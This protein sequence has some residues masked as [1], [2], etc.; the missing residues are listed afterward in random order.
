MENITTILVDDE[1]LALNRMADILKHFKQINVI[2][3][4]HDPEEAIGRIGKTKPEI[5]FLDV[6]IKDVA[7]V[8]TVAT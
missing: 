1:K 3:K 2:S 8:D 6:E 7:S 4:E 5:V